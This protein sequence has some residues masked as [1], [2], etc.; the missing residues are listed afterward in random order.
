MHMINLIVL[1]IDWLILTACQ[2]VWG[3]FILRSLGITFVFIFWDWYCFRD[4]ILFIFGP[5]SLQ[6][7]IIDKQ[8]CLTHWQIVLPVK[9]NLGVIELKRSSTFAGEPVF[10][11][12]QMMQLLYFKQCQEGALFLCSNFEDIFFVK[13]KRTMFQ[14]RYIYTKWTEVMKMYRSKLRES[15]RTLKNSPSCRVVVFNADRL[16][17]QFSHELCFPKYYSFK[18][19]FFP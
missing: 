19:R 2:S 18:H 3:Y 16:R 14:R 13:A 17:S 5:W 6:I 10:I 4:L 11:P 8:I 15:Y 7:R 1:F 12:L 9:V